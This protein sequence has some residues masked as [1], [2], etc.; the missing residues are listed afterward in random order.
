[1]VRLSW[2]LVLMVTFVGL[3]SAFVFNL[4]VLA[5]DNL[6]AAILVDWDDNGKVIHLAKGQVLQLSLSTNPSTGYNWQFVK[7]PRGKALK[8]IT[9]YP[10]TPT[11]ALVGAPVMEHS[12]FYAVKAG[13][14]AIDLEYV[15]S[16]ETGAARNFY[17]KVKIR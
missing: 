12:F 17:V 4:P 8:F 10:E 14:T 7:E 1:M 15:R 9:S 5:L 16:W 2:R 3:I 13:E 11:S 6:E